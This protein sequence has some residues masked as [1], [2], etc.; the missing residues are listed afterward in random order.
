[1]LGFSARRGRRVE[2]QAR[3]KVNLGLEVLGRLPDGYHELR[4]VMWAIDLADRVSLE[5]RGER[6]VHLECDVPE[7]P[8]TPDNLAW[9]AADLLCRASGLRHGVRIRVAK[10]IPV[11][12][13]LGGGS[14]DAAAV[15]AGLE[16]LWGVRL[17]SVR[18]RAL[19]TE[20]GMDVPFFLGRSPALASGRGERLRPL[21]TAMEL[22][23]V[24]VN[25][26]FA[27]ATRDVYACLRPGDFSDGRQVAA[28][29]RALGRD[30]A[31]VAATV[32][33]GLEAAAARLWPGLGEVKAALVEAGCRAALMSGSGPTVVGIA[34]SR[35]AAA[36]IRGALDRGSWRV[37]T[38]RTVAGPVLAMRPIPHDGRV[39][40]TWGVAKR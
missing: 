10:R 9:R 8:C 33:N 35:R 15:L 34:P 2:V 31:A 17:G 25:P 14:A 21:R 13:G 19:A 39:G 28:L 1:V 36:R 22:P 4:S 5:S 18:R 7:V 16:R 30:V 38:A 26:G 6:G 27:L 37:W 12:A 3:A 23:L 20:L 40:T 11:A 24:L 32:V 29:V